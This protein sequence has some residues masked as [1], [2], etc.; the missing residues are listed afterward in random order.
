MFRRIRNVKKQK[1]VKNTVLPSTTSITRLDPNTQF[2]MS[3]FISP[4]WKSKYAPANNEIL[5]NAAV[6]TKGNQITGQEIY[7][8]VQYP[9]VLRL[10]EM[11]QRPPGEWTVINAIESSPKNETIVNVE[12][13]FQNYIKEMPQIVKDNI[14]KDKMFMFD[15]QQKRGF[16]RIIFASYIEPGGCIPE[17]ENT[18]LEKDFRRETTRLEEL[19]HE[20]YGKYPVVRI[21]D[22]YE[23]E[24]LQEYI[25]RAETKIDQFFQP[26]TI[27]DNDMIKDS[28]L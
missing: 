15:N 21:V 28:F 26:K 12:N 9:A 7:P 17:P 11:P 5:M 8:P 16:T 24:W 23:E 2:L 4:M 13:M 20:L 10:P 27:D 22:E 6:K 14:I 18:R 25:E 3:E 1:V 19:Y